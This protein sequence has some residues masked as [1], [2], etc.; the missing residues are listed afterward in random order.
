MDDFASFTEPSPTT[1]PGFGAW[2]ERR[3]SELGRR[4]VCDP[5]KRLGQPKRPSAD[6]PHSEGILAASSPTLW[7]TCWPSLLM[8]FNSFL[9]YLMWNLA[10]DISFGVL[11][12]RWLSLRSVTVI[13]KKVLLI[14][15]EETNILIFSTFTEKKMEV[16]PRLNLLL[17]GFVIS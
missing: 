10:Q 3:T 11:C 1:W 5:G 7:N 2:K 16:A 17:S 6:R 4:A 12:H 15:F 8:Y 13:K 9:W 14:D